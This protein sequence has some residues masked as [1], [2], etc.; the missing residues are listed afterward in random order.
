MK[1]NKHL[2]LQNKDS[3]IIE[4]TKYSF[5]YYFFEIIKFS[6]TSQCQHQIVVNLNNS[7]QSFHFLEKNSPN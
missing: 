6:Q 5:Y 2:L 1:T 3:V 4:M 7:T